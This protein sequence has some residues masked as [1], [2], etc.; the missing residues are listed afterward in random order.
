MLAM[1]LRFVFDELSCPRR[2][3]IVEIPVRGEPRIKSGAGSVEIS[4]RLSDDEEIQ[5]LN[6]DYRGK[7]KP[8]NILSFPMLEP[9]DVADALKRWAGLP[10]AALP[11]TSR[12]R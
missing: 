5:R 1:D 10:C 7:D 12:W 9:A 4:V 3:G 8:T 11:R 6:R 2:S